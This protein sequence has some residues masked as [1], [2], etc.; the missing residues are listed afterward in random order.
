MTLFAD[1]ESD[2][3]KSIQKA[4]LSYPEVKK[5]KRHLEQKALKYIPLEKETIGIVGGL[6]LSA[7]R[8]YVDT[9]VVKNM[10]LRFENGSIR[11]NIRYNIKDSSVNSTINLHWSF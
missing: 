1:E 5:T 11:P 10:Q 8:G 3:I 2:A 7:M 4:I 9:N 6:V